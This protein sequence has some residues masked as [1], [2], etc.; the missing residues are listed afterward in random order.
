MMY[1]DDRNEGNIDGYYRALDIDS[2]V[3]HVLYQRNGVRYEREYL[4]SNPDK[5]IAV[6][7]TASQ[8]KSINVDIR[9]SSQVPHRVK[10]SQNQLTMLGHAIGDERN[11]IHFCSILLVFNTCGSVVVSDSTLQLRD[12]DEATL[13][14]VNATSFNG[15]GLAPVLI[16]EEQPEAA[17]RQE[18]ESQPVAQEEV[19]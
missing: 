18:Q 8:P 19:V 10:A 7:L 12:V 1:I 13:C 16:W 2:A 4:A 6:H 11:S 3:A 14:F 15:F 5:V 17:K 9:L